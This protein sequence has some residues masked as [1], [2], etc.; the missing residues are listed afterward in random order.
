VVL[1]YKQRIKEDSETGSFFELSLGRS[2]KKKK[3]KQLTQPNFFCFFYPKLHKIIMI[4]LNKERGGIMLNNENVIYINN[5]RIEYAGLWIKEN[6]NIKSFKWTTN[7]NTKESFIQLPCL[8]VRNQKYESIQLFSFSY[9]PTKG[10]TYV[11]DIKNKG[12][13]TLENL[14]DL[15]T[16]II[17]SELTIFSTKQILRNSIELIFTAQEGA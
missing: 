8:F 13:F 6:Q 1:R 16:L 4:F 12:S 10:F 3:Y 9:H 5:D 2:L 15:A 14:E 7:R 17:K 11:D